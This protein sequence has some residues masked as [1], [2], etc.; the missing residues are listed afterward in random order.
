MSWQASRTSFGAERRGALGPRSGHSRRS[1]RAGSSCV[2]ARRRR[3]RTRSRT[4]ALTHRRRP[5]PGGCPRA[6]DC[7]RAGIRRRRRPPACRRSRRCA[8]RACR[9]GRCARPTSPASERACFPNARASA[10][11]S[12]RGPLRPAACGSRRPSSLVR[13][14]FSSICCVARLRARV[15][16]GEHLRGR[17]RLAGVEQQQLIAQAPEHVR[18]RAPAARPPRCRPDR[19]CRRRSRRAPQRTGPACPPARRA[20]RSRSRTLPR[21]GLRA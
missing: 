10:P 19:R 5:S 12:R 2:L 1:R 17:A 14:R 16:V 15:L 21:R 6:G 9:A 18:R 11:R 8:A 13:C 3:R 20:R 4:S 7:R